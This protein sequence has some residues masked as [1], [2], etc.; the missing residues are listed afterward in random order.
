MKNIYNLL[1]FGSLVLGAASCSK[2]LDINENPNSATTATP[3]VML[4]QALTATAS[5]SNSYNTMGAQ[6]GGYM[7]NA[8]GYGG[9]GVNVTYNFSNSSYSGLW[10]SSYDNL[11]DYQWIIDSTAGKPEYGYYNAAAKVMKAFNY[12]L[13]VDAYNDVPYSAA[14][15]RE[16][17]LTPKYDDAKSVYDSCYSLLTQAQAIF[18][19]TKALT[20]N[21]SAVSF[22]TQDVMFA[23]DV[24][25]W[26]Q[27][28]NTLKLR[29][30]IRARGLIT[31]P[32]NYSSEGFLTTNAIV[33]PGYAQ[34]NG[35]QNPEYNSWAYSYT[36]S[37]GTRSWIAS[38]WIANLYDGSVI[39]SDGRGYAC[40]YNFGA[41]SFASNQLGYESSSV[42]S[43]PAGGS[44]LT[45]F[46]DK[47]NN[48]GI[49]KGPAMG[50][51]LLTAAESYFLQ[52]EAALEGDLGVSGSASTFFYNGIKSS[53]SYLYMKRDGTYDLTNWDPTADEAAYETA[54]AGTYLVNFSLATTA[55]QKLEAIITQKYI[56]VNMINS[57]EGW[58]EYRRT[59]YPKIVNGSTD[60]TL[61][62]ASRQSLSSQA[63]KLPTRIM[64]PT[65]EQ[66]V[67]NGNVPKGIS[68]FTSFI[69]WAKKN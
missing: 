28:A 47:A 29:L 57:Q 30:A 49:L 36:G 40:L 25:K 24:T 60:G 33:N 51:P 3:M 9:F 69:F 39:Q 46:Y 13:L 52:S 32:N 38:K 41:S 7:A 11:T 12:Q 21:P 26:K 55:A 59:H 22:S 56:A 42:P 35:R 63:D 34:D 61:T 20:D 17:D 54:N 44:W 15:L 8:G 66:S 62:F 53:F 37:N 19:A 48:I 65:V 5:L 68:P 27:F 58:N 2:Y 31:F 18:D 50:Q 4:P 45:G 6:I 67:N 1:I 10:S 23:G 43:S 16:K 14:F 64:Y